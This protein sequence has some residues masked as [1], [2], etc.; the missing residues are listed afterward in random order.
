M[1]IL[2]KFILVDEDQNL[3]MTT[4]LEEPDPSIDAEFWSTFMS[5]QYA[6]VFTGT[7]L[8]DEE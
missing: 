1:T 2:Y 4:H 7:T 3:V 5:G 6:M 8:E